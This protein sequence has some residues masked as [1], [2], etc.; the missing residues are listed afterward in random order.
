MPIPNGVEIGG[1]VRNQT[2]RGWK[3][4]ILGNQKGSEGKLLLLFIGVGIGIRVLG[5]VEGQDFADHTVPL[6]KEEGEK[7]KEN[8]KERIEWDLVPQDWGL[9]IYPP[10][11]YAMVLSGFE[12]MY[13]VP[14]TFSP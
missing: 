10:K 7:E 11:S 14:C 13:L 8:C 12:R 5:E 2:S 9:P 6:L 4:G 1:Q 3:G